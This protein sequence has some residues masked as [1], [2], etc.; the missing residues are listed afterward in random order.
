[1]SDYRCSFFVSSQ[2]FE[3][4][5]KFEWVVRRKE[6]TR[7]EDDDAWVLSVANAAAERAAEMLSKGGSGG[8]NGSV[9]S[10]RQSGARGVGAGLDESIDFEKVDY[11]GDYQIN[12]IM[13]DWNEGAIRDAGEIEKERDEQLN[14]NGERK[15]ENRH[16]KPRVFKVKECLEKARQQ[17]L[18]KEAR[19][20][21]V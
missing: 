18:E 8:G 5:K 20:G 19:N 7:T 6:R 21:G 4:D 11:V 3:E 12:G 13:N 1:M 16:W 10:K 14:R 2:G 9:T 15:K 17:R